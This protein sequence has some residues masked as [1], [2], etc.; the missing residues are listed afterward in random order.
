[1]PLATVWP[2]ATPHCGLHISK[3][4]GWVTTPL[5]HLGKTETYACYQENADLE[6]QLLVKSAYTGGS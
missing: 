4:S 1:M 2:L 5:L 3:P 6:F